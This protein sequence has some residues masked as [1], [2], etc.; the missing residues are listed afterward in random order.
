MFSKQIVTVL[1]TGLAAAACA[2]SGRTPG[3]TASGAIARPLEVYE[4]LGFV[5][6]PA[7]FPAVASFS[8]IAGPA[9]STYVLIGISMPSSALRF[10]RDASGFLGEYVI[11]I[12][13]RRDSALVRRLERRENVR[14]GSFAETGRTDESI[15]FQ[16][17]VALPP[18]KYHITVDARDAFSSKGMRT[19]DSLQIQGYADGRHLSP[20]ILVYA[21][22]GRTTRAEA[23]DLVLNPRKTVSYGTDVPR[24]YFELYDAPSPDTV[25]LRVLDDRAT[26]VWTKTT[27]VE[28]GTEALR[29]TTV[30]IPVDSLPPG[31]LWLESSLSGDEAEVI[32]SP[33]LVTISDQW[34]I[35]NVDEVLRFVTYIAFPA[36]LDSL[37]NATGAARRERWESFW[38]RRDPLPATPV[39]E[40][41]ED[42][43]QRVRFATEHYAEPGRPGWETDR[44][45]VY[46][47]LGRPDQEIERHI[48]NDVGAQPNAVEWLFERTPNGRIQLLFV[49]RTG[50]GRFELTPS[51]EQTFRT[52][53]HRLRPEKQR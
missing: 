28:Q 36:E 6:G 29:Y 31:R 27:V 20:P 44:G 41:R 35:A 12:A 37:R 42:F 24:V 19:R 5:A 4:Q 10:Q 52:T 32:R 50:F 3:S 14:V 40:F 43:F 38:A 51:S 22:E 53:A 17:L 1:L 39:N 8:T 45:E 13:F 2:R 26:A 11:D 15:I 33:L 9:D 16:D 25:T 48:G 49:D 7:D 34:M 18:G 46:I 23:P 47:V 30:D 21:S